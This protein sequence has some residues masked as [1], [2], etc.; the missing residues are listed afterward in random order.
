MGSIKIVGIS[1]L[2]LICINV[3]AQIEIGGLLDLEISE[4]GKDSDFG[5]NEIVSDYRKSHL[6]INQFNLFIF[7]EL[8]ESFSVNARLQ[9]DTWGSGQLNPVR[10][11]LAEIMWAPP[12][13]PVQISLGRFVNPFGLYPQRQLSIQNLFVNTPLAYGYAVNVTNQ[14]GI[15]YYTNGLP[16]LNGG[17]GGYGEGAGKLTTINFAGYTT[18]ALFS[19][20]LVSEVLNLDVAVTNVALASQKHYTNRQNLAGIAR[21]SFKPAIFWQQGVSFS[22]GSFME[23]A[24]VNTQINDLEQ[25]KQTIIGTDWLISFTYFEISGEFIHANW[26]LPVF[27]ADSFLTNSYDKITGYDFKNYSYYIDLKYEP[28]FISGSY[29]A[30]RF[31]ELIFKEYDSPSSGYGSE[32]TDPII[33]G[34]W[35]NSIRR[36]SVAM[37]YKFSP[38]IQLK[39]AYSNQEY[40]DLS[41]KPDAYTIRSILSASF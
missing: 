9:F 28:S 4:G 32:S 26:N 21:I 6:A 1:L 3:S 12:E 24:E 40:L 31:E 35:D 11:A 27:E 37:G 16:A 17:Y 30:L 7:S 33:E 29:I 15:L 5:V 41:A 18:G 8:S 25:F 20:L 38:N 34:R 10:V 39:V 2:F 23:R 19:W 14:H 22:H 36:Y 13:S